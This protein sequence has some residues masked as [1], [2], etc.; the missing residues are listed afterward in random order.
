MSVIIQIRNVPEPLHR[1][2]EARAAR[3]RMSLSAYVLGE[4]RKVA[5]LPTAERLPQRKPVTPATPAWEI[6]RAER[7]TR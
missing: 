3:A 5:E 2:L 4:L 7:D 1:E 6:I